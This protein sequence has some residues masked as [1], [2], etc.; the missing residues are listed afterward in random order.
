MLRFSWGSKETHKQIPRKPQENARTHPGQSRENLV[1][2]FSSLLFFSRPSL[3]F[4]VASSIMG[5][6]KSGAYDLPSVSLK[7]EGVGEGCCW[8]VF[9]G[10]PS[11][12]FYF[13]C[14]GRVKGESEAPGGG[15]VIGFLLKIPGKEGIS[16]MGGAGRVP[17][18]NWGIFGGGAKVFFSGLKYP[19]SFLRSREAA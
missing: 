18:A 2:A 9:L 3:H 6:S 13:F 10:N 14:S 19:P 7:A 16:R 17:A 8:Q 11:I 1:C 15:W 12:G 5:V 4:E